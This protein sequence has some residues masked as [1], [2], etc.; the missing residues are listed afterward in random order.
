MYIIDGIAYAGEKTPTIQVKSVRPLKDYKLWLRFNTNEEKIFDFSP[1][2]GM[3]VF[4]P[5][6]DKALFDGVYVDF[7]V[8]TWMDGE[9]DLA[10]E[11]LYAEG[12]VVQGNIH[13]M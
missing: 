10:P 8:P 3:P 7:G 1:L 6:K 9:I 13:A 4:A 5:L 11:K 2:L 12:I